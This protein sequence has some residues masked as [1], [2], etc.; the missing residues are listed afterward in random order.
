MNPKNQ[1]V[2]SGAPDLTRKNIHNNNLLT[3]HVIYKLDFTRNTIRIMRHKNFILWK[4]RYLT[5]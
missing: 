2:N 1:G 4:I 3:Y 5:R